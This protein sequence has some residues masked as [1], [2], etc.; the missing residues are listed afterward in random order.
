M[1]SHLCIHMKSVSAYAYRSEFRN[2]KNSPYMAEWRDLMKEL[3]N[4][5][6]AGLVYSQTHNSEKLLSPTTITKPEEQEG[7]MCYQNPTI[8]GAMEEPPNKSCSEKD[9]HSHWIHSSVWLRRWLYHN[10]LV[11]SSVDR[12]FSY[13]QSFVLINDV[14]IGH[15]SW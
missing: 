1:W 15:A 13:L 5:L 3:H 8:S 12:C 11:H 7:E 4:E 9:S 6:W 14:A 2:K 10:A